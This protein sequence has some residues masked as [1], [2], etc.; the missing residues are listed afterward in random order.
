VAS[1]LVF[2]GKNHPVGNNVALTE[3]LCDVPV[4]FNGLL[5]RLVV[6]SML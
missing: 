3:D 2:S 6:A 4:C 1:L 5:Q